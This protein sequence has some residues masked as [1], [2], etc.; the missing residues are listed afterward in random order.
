MKAWLALAIM[1]LAF[2]PVTTGSAE[3]GE[4]RPFIRGS[5]QNIRNLHAG[6]PTVVH[7]WGLTCGP[8]RVE[9]PH[10]GALLRERPDLNLVLINAD[11]APDDPGAVRAWLA[12][13][14]L[15]TAE[16]WI[17][18]DAF[19]E[20][21]RFEIDPQWQGEIPL[22]YLIDRDGRRTTIEGVANVKDIR[23]WLDGQGTPRR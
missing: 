18:D 9:M 10:W 3:V 12:K 22:T 6:R 1:L 21:L 20:R 4:L 15:A 19:T 16:N 5:W 11:M 8:C 14:G 23:A 17:F 7:F 2:N 13:T